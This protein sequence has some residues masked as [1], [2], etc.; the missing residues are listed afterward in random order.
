MAPPPSRNATCSRIS[1]AN[2]SA[3]SVVDA[4]D[5]WMTMPNAMS[6]STVHRSPLRGTAGCASRARAPAS[7]SHWPHAAK[8]PTAPYFFALLSMKS[9][10]SW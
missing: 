8:R 3:G 9:M 4:C 1:A 5:I 2:S 7:S 10:R 6:A